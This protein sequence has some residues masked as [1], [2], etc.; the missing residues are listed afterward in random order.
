[1]RPG[2][3]PH[4]IQWVTASPLWSTASQEP[5]RMRAPQLLRFES[6]HF[7][8][9]L[10][11]R[12]Q[13]LP[14][15]DLSGHVVHPAG[16]GAPPL[17]LFQPAHGHFYLV[18][19]NL[20]CRLAG[21]P[22]HAVDTA[23]GERATFV[24]R[25]LAEDGTEQAWVPDPQDATRQ[26]HQ[27]ASLARGAEKQ[28]APSEELFPMFPVS[29]T[30]EGRRRRLLVGFV[31]TSSRETFQSAASFAPPGAEGSALENQV[32][33][34]VVAPY[35]FLKAIPSTQAEAAPE[36]DASRFLLLDLATFLQQHLPAHWDALSRATPPPASARTRALHD[37]LQGHR[38]GSGTAPTWREALRTAW[39][40]RDVI[41]AGEPGTLGPNLRFSTLPVSTLRSGLV[42]AVKDSP[43]EPPTPS[44]QVP[45][46]E[47]PGEVRYVIRCV[48]QRP[49]CGALQPP[50]VSE[51]SPDFTL[52]AFFDP[53]AP[54]R[55]MHI[56]LPVDTSIAGLR[57]FKKNVHFTLSKKLR[58]QMSRASDL[59]DVMD[60]KL[61]GGTTF[62]L[63]EICSFSLPIIT[64]CAFIV[65]MIFLALLNIV[66]WW[67]PFL[68][69]CLP[70]VKAK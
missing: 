63:G 17:K 65:L 2:L 47:R 26:R 1:M 41:S 31:P 16:A 30:V 69:I 33:D 24:L 34:Q 13:A 21:L 53:D 3:L 14:R 39:D 28:L 19:A 38:I 18:A 52:A 8:E 23:R 60:K 51:P 22:D 25:R 54:A 6:E 12:L 61:P 45:K 5:V 50:L 36:E 27:W 49:R 42:N 68:K 40:E 55:E 4:Q 56:T 48:Y 44:G 15:P 64:L 35:A 62:D 46:L 59:Q 10:T 57:K 43:T 37:L 66:F 11:S 20:V 7:M 9:E 29:F 67:L 58:E 32:E 70:T